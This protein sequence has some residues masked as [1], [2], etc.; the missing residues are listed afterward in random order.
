MVYC[1]G[2]HRVTL[3]SFN[4]TNAIK[5]IDLPDKGTYQ[6]LS[7]L[8]DMKRRSPTVPERREIVDFDDAGRFAGLLI[9]S[10]ID[11]VMVNTNEAAYGGNVEDVRKVFS[12]VRRIKPSDPTP[13]VAKDIIVHPIQVLLI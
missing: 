8:C 7:V 2:F 4:L 3:S 9:K 6:T 10:G 13:I 12:A 11:A 5:R 1:T